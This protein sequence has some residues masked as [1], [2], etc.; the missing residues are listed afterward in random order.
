MII[1]L[2]SKFDSP[3]LRAKSRKFYLEV[4]TN[5]IKLSYSLYLEIEAFNEG[6]PKNL[7]AV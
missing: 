5:I 7:N 6:F 4:S 1:L 3:N 2:K